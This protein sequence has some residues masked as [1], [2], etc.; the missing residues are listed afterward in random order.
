MTESTSFAAVKPISNKR[1]D[2]HNMTNQLTI[3]KSTTN[4]PEKFSRREPTSRFPPICEKSDSGRIRDRLLNRLGIEK[5]HHIQETPD[6]SNVSALRHSEDVAFD[7]LLKAD[8]GMPDA[9]LAERIRVSRAD[10]ATSPGKD[11]PLLKNLRKG[12]A[13]DASVKVLPIPSRTCYSNR[14]RNELWMAP[15]EIQQNAARNSLEFAA[16]GWNWENVAEDSD[17]VLY[18]GE[19]VHPIHFVDEFSLDRRFCRV[20]QKQR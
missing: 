5:E 9:R 14:I 2:E 13:F 1:L 15:E 19:L 7:E 16:E 12:V 6:R 18:E 10:L 3:V 20:L 11:S 8:Y 4:D 17:M